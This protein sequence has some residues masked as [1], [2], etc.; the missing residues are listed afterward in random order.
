LQKPPEESENFD[1]PSPSASSLHSG[2]ASIEITSMPNQNQTHTKRKTMENGN[3]RG[4]ELKNKEIPEKMMKIV[5]TR[6]KLNKLSKA[7][8]FCRA[9]TGCFV[10][11]IAPGLSEKH[12]DLILVSTT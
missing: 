6:A 7:P 8:S 11:V 5:L 10:R 12:D 3:G 1:V 2:S 9:V 4:S